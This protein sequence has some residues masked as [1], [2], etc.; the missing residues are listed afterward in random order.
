MGGGKKKKSDNNDPLAF[1]QRAQDE[2]QKKAQDRALQ[3]QENSAAW[4]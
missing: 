2:K 1:L 4:K 3:E